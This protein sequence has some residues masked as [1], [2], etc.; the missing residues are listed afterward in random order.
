VGTLRS[1]SAAGEDLGDDP[2]VAV[3]DGLHDRLAALEVNVR[4]DEE[5]ELTSE[6]GHREAALPHPRLDG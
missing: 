2:R 4:S 5:W 1:E 6:A 3:T